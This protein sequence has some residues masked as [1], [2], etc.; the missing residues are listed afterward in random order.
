MANGYNMYGINPS[1]SGYVSPSWGMQPLQ[2]TTTPINWNGA[3]SQAP[4]VNNLNYLPNQTTPVANQATNLNTA[5]SGGTGNASPISFNNIAPVTPNSLN[6]SPVN[7]T[8]VVNNN[9][10]SLNPANTLTDINAQSN[11]G[12]TSSITEGAA[13]A[14]VANNPAN[15][16]TLNNVTDTSLLERDSFF[17]GLSNQDLFSGIGQGLKIGAGVFN[18][19]NA[20]QNAQTAAEGLQFRKDAYAQDYAM[21]KA[22]YERRLARQEGKDEALSR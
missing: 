19:Y 21:R 5:L 18:A 20:W 9:V 8:P 6:T 4:R 13:L 7:T 15:V 17:D 10:Q 22:D 12:L 16:D 1:M 3:L 14:D 11:M 2:Q